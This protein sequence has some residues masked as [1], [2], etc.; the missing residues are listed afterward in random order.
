MSSFHTHTRATNVVTRSY[1]L[2][3][4]EHD[5][6]TGIRPCSWMSCANLIEDHVAFEEM[7]DVVFSRGAWN[8]V[9]TE[10]SVTGRSTVFELN[11]FDRIQPELQAVSNVLMRGWSIEK[12][13]RMGRDYIGSG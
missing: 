4:P 6:Y 7:A 1:V 11:H 3:M 10:D 5:I 2:D 13:G 9:Y 12:D 8:I